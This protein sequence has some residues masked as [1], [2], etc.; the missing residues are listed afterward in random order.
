MASYKQELI[1][2]HQLLAEVRFHVN[3]EWNHPVDI[4]DLDTYSEVGITSMD[5]NA[6]IET[7]KEAVLALASDIATAFEVTGRPSQKTTADTSAAGPTEQ[8]TLY[9][10][11]N[12]SKETAEVE[13][14]A[15][16]D[17]TETPDTPDDPVE[18]P[19]QD[20]RVIGGYDTDTV[21]PPALMNT[22]L[23]DSWEAV[24]ER[25]DRKPVE[26]WGAEPAETAST[27][28]PAHPDADPAATTEA[29]GEQSQLAVDVETKA[30]EQP[31]DAEEPGEQMTLPT[32]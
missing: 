12:W 1:Q 2:L 19:G 25:E 11:E 18:Q 9:D 26:T 17:T 14:T 16:P 4:E 15:T 20:P 28:S 24:K 8:P 32:P 31:V 23:Q 13:A 10:V 22:S 21:E 29:D 30:D 27:D 3:D 7:Q 5:L 6:E